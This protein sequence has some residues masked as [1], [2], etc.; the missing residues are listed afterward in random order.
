MII[1]PEYLHLGDLINIVH[2]NIGCTIGVNPGVMQSGKCVFNTLREIF[3]ISGLSL[4]NL[5]PESG[6]PVKQKWGV[7]YR[8]SPIYC[9]K[10]FIISYC[11]GTRSLGPNMISKLPEAKLIDQFLQFPFCLKKVD[12]DGNLS[13]VEK[14]KIL[15]SSLFYVGAD[16]GISHLALLTDT[17]IVVFHSR[18]FDAKKFYNDC[19]Q[20]SFK[21]ELPELIKFCLKKT[22]RV[23]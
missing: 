9:R 22:P 15:A 10:K 19:D 17:P 4:E 6:F 21:T 18:F 8:K 1:T 11:F 13:L 12:I 14:Y 7:K 2:S 23:F 5:V 3:Y 20:I 16:N